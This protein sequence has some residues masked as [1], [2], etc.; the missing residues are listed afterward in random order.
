[1]WKIQYSHY[2]GSIHVPIFAHAKTWERERPIPFLVLA[3]T[4]TTEFVVRSLCTMHNHLT[5]WC[6][7]E[8]DIGDASNKREVAAVVVVTVVGVESW[9][10]QQWEWKRCQKVVV[11]GSCDG[12]G[13]RIR[14]KRGRKGECETNYANQTRAQFF[15]KT[16]KE[17]MLFNIFILLIENAN[18]HAVPKDEE[19]KSFGIL[20]H[21]C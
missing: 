6:T 21:Q 15:H 3:R 4:S 16:M 7:I 17:K 9:Q 14:W 20:I 2:T 12:R 10:R 11:L 8:W 5:G 18:T 19:Q 1:M 13:G